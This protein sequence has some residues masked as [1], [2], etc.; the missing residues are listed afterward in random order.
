[1]PE[2]LLFALSCWIVGL[3]AATQTDWVVRKAFRLQQ[4]YPRVFTS[5]LAER[6]WYPGYVRLGGITLL[7]FAFIFTAKVF[8]ETWGGRLIE[9]YITANQHQTVERVRQRFAQ[10]I[11]IGS[12]RSAV[13]NYLDSL[14]ISH[15]YIDDSRFPNE[16]R[17]EIALIRATHRWLIRRDVQ[18]RFH[19]D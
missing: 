10:T 18:I 14:S 1:M 2:D 17:V 15:S 19:F 16:Q 12:S 8:F 6:R 5:R 11:P 9:S 7:V 13:E 4:R 3:V